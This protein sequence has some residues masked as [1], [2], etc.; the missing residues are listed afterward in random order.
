MTLPR[1]HLDGHAKP[2]GRAL[3]PRPHRDNHL[4]AGQLVPIDDQ[5]WPSQLRLALEVP[6]GNPRLVSVRVNDRLLFE[7]TL[8]PG[9]VELRLDISS[10]PRSETAMIGISTDGT[11]RVYEIELIPELDE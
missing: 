2:L 11:I 1:L 4:V 6:D 10:E 9:P 7:D 5:P 3:A 8:R